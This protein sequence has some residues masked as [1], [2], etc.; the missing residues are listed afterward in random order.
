MD[1]INLILWIKFNAE[2]TIIMIKIFSLEQPQALLFNKIL[3]KKYQCNILVEMKCNVIDSKLLYDLFYIHMQDKSG[4]IIEPNFK[5]VFFVDS[6]A[7]EQLPFSAEL[8]F[9]NNKW[10]QIKK[11]RNVDIKSISI[12]L[13]VQSVKGGKK[14][15]VCKWSSSQIKQSI[16]SVFPKFYDSDKI[17]VDLLINGSKE[18]SISILD[19]AQNI[20]FHFR[21][22]S[23]NPRMEKELFNEC[24]ISANSLLETTGINNEDFVKSYSISKNQQR[25]HSELNLLSPK[26]ARINEKLSISWPFTIPDGFVLITDRLEDFDLDNA[27]NSLLV[28][29]ITVDYHNEDGFPMVTPP[30]NRLYIAKYNAS[31][32]YWEFPSENDLK[33]NSSSEVVKEFYKSKIHKPYKSEE[34]SI[35]SSYLEL[36]FEC[37]FMSFFDDFIP[38]SFKIEAYEKTI[39]VYLNNLNSVYLSIDL[40]TSAICVVTL[41]MGAKVDKMVERIK[42]QTFTEPEKQ[43]EPDDFLHPT[44]IFFD[45]KEMG[46]GMEIDFDD[47]IP[48]EI[49]SISM[50]GNKG[51]PN[52]KMLMLKELLLIGEKKFESKEIVSKIFEILLKEILSKVSPSLQGKK[53]KHIIFSHPNT[54]NN[55]Y[56]NIYDNSIKVVKK[57]LKLSNKCKS[58]IV[59]ESESTLMCYIVN[60][61]LPDKKFTASSIV[62]L[63]IGAG[64]TDITFANI[65]RE[66]DKITANIKSSTCFVAGGNFYDFLLAEAFSVMLNK[67]IDDVYSD[68][69]SDND[70]LKDSKKKNKQ[71][72]M[73]SPSMFIEA[74][75]SKDKA[76]IQKN[77]EYLVIQKKFKRLITQLKQNIAGLIKDD[78]KTIDEL[79]EPIV[80]LLESIGLINFKDNHI[81]KLMKSLA[82]IGDT[83]IS[84]ALGELKLSEQVEKATVG[85]V[86][87]ILDFIGFNE[88][89]TASSLTV[90]VSGRASRFELVQNALEG[91]VLKEKYKADVVNLYNDEVATEKYCVA[92]GAPFI[93]H[94]EGTNGSGPISINNEYKLPKLYACFQPFHAALVSNQNKK[95]AKVLIKELTSGKDSVI[96]SSGGGKLTLLTTFDAKKYEENEYSIEDIESSPYLNDSVRQQISTSNTIT[97]RVEEKDKALKVYVNDAHHPIVFVDEKKNNQETL[98]KRLFNESMWPDSY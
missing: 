20:D 84:S 73:L 4:S 55:Q 75:A 10:E 66:N 50:A 76:V 65:R 53:V 18:K 31:K 81:D 86:E 72:K 5:G 67:L 16:I 57:M 23:F 49:S 56:K 54:F 58:T 24:N 38:E 85:Q 2:F 7:F 32:N 8:K 37:Q 92:E 14:N 19:N 47:K 96:D 3:K 80:V 74:L 91:N 27:Y 63:D 93:A 1:V 78:R 39:T 51:L 69:S 95:D 89:D 90:V 25:C 52:I 15:E 82:T 34:H 44:I 42:L 36:R 41:D 22:E 97:I 6:D 26:E 77:S 17:E 30:I 61:I 60:H 43:I 45:I 83:T 28:N 33:I 98:H 11:L 88:R 35:I 48:L 29:E 46:M 9:N 12:A 87:N 40:G 59:S 68:N 21:I 13:S 70:A 79:K 64:T 62:V 71:K 94:Y